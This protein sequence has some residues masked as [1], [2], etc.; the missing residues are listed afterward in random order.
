[1]DART[2]SPRPAPASVGF[3][4][5]AAPKARALHGLPDPRR[6]PR[7]YRGVAT[8]RA[9]AWVI[10]GG[11]TLALCLLILPFTAFVGL[12]F[13]SALWMT[14]GFLYRWGT[15]ASGSATWGMRAMALT[16][17]ERDGARLSGG[18]ALAHTVGY[19]L[20]LA[21][22]PLQL[23]SVAL[24]AGLGR[25]QGLTDMVLGTAMLNRPE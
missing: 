24:M 21:M 13:W 1:M 17:R 10:D 22:I 19:S 2:T 6:E 7:F 11:I 3:G 23:I 18:T 12:F 4:H 25:G 20:S 5:A 8:K 14:V 9:L 16:L 15:L